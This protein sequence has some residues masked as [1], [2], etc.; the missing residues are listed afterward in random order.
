MLVNR[1]DK[2][3]CC[4]V[5]MRGANT[6]GLVVNV[7]VKINLI[8]KGLWQCYIRRRV[9][10]LRASSTTKSRNQQNEADK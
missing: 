8:G 6:F 10:E 1:E 5:T 4:E 7:V 2:L 9:G 3:R